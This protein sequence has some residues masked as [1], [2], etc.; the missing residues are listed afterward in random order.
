MLKKLKDLSLG[1]LGFAVMIGALVLAVFLMRGAVWAS[2]K[3]LPWLVFG[4]EVLLLICLVVLLP[5]CIFR[6]TRLSAAVGFYFGSYLFG[7]TLW[8]FSCL[9]CVAIWGYTALIIGLLLAGVGVF[10]VALIAALFHGEWTVLLELLI[11]LILTFGTRFAGVILIKEEETRRQAEAYIE[12]VTAREAE[13]SE[14][15]Q[16]WTAA[17]INCDFNLAAEELIAVFRMTNSEAKSKGEEAHYRE[18]FADPYT[19]FMIAPA[20]ET[21]TPLLEVAPDL[22]EVFS[23]CCPGGDSYETRRLLE[24]ETS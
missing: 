23:R 4:S 14:S 1:V 21:A 9:V 10:P 24:D 8:A 2:D 6:K 11:G 16:F 13:K 12:S 7:V 5:M 18:D 15:R 22:Y 3:A 20:L 17:L 19:A